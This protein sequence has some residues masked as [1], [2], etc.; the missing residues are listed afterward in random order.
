MT[1][2]STLTLER[3]PIEWTQLNEMESPKFKDLEHGGI[4]K[5][6]QLFEN[7]HQA[8]IKVDAFRFS[9]HCKPQL[10][11]ARRRLRIPNKAPEGRGR[12]TVFM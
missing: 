4:K 1:I 3:F 5:V 2:K 6:G 8:P 7:I 10:D 12:R 9:T 11:G